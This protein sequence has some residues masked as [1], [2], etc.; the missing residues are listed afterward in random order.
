MVNLRSLRSN[1]AG[2]RKV[3]RFAAAITGGFEPR[4]YTRNCMPVFD[5]GGGLGA[6]RSGAPSEPG[7]PSSLVSDQGFPALQRH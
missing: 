5:F 4:V 6:E 1:D 2:L 7:L 3:D